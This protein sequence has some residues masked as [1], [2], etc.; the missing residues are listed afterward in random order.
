M[1]AV[2]TQLREQIAAHAASGEPLAIRGGGSKEFYGGVIRGEPLELGAYTGI[3]DYQP[4][5]LVLTVRAGT[6]LADI[7]AA[8]DAEGQM[9][10]FEPPHFDE[11]ATVGSTIGGT[12]ATGLSGPRRAYTG[13][14]RDFLLGA[15]ILDG[16]GDDLR[17]G[18]R[19]I[20]NVAGYDVS[21]LLCGAMGTLG[22][23]LD[24]SFKTLPKSAA[25]TTLRFE[26]DEATAVRK[27]NEWAGMPL[28]LSGASWEG[29]VA[30]LRLSGAEAGVAAA[31]AKLG[32]DVVEPGV[33]DAFW[34]DLR[35]QRL[36]CFRSTG[37]LWRLSV[38]PT[39]APISFA[40]GQCIDWGGALRWI[41]AT[42]DANS[43][44]DKVAAV[45]GHATLFRGGDKSV[46][47]F[48][49]LAPAL[50][51]IHRN[52]KAAFDPHGIFN[53]GRMDNF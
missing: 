52:L 22:V 8:L 31:R 30:M 39:A 48:H 49:P 42:D 13:A 50:A 36:P 3:V 38:P 10:P 43:I 16:R 19:V 23:L 20:K 5:E 27:F 44:R 17:F 47:V 6:P 1:E 35:E 24:L 11:G 29:G 53:P 45:G 9:L 28:P 15:R 32:G 41:V 18:G 46:G 25:E 51:Q 2:V 40:V 34:R 14:V 33:A 21:R 4:K 12:V 26:F 37:P 7:E